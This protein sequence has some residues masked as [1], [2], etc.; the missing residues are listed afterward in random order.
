MTLDLVHFSPAICQSER[1]ILIS[2]ARSYLEFT[3][4]DRTGDI[5]MG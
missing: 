5:K 4:E 3:D 2:Q 1:K